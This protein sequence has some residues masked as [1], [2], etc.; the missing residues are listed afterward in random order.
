MK[1]FPRFLAITG[2]LS[3]LVPGAARAQAADPHATGL[4]PCT[5][6]ELAWQNKHMLRVKKVKLNALGLAR[7]NAA[8][9][10]KG[11][12]ALGAAPVRVGAEV[13]GTVGGAPSAAAEEGGSE[14]PAADLPAY[15]D[16]SSLKY[17]P[18]I[19]SQG[20]LPSCACFSG[21]YYVMTYM[22]AMAN[23]LDAKSGGDAVRLS[24]KFTYNFVNDGAAVGSWYYWAYDIGKKHGCATW[25]EFPYDSNYRAWPMSGA[26]YRSAINKRFDAYGYVSGTN[27]DSGIQQVKEMLVN[28][29]I[30]NI[31]TYVNSWQYRTIGNDPAT[32]EDDAFV[33]KSAC[34]WVNGTNGYHAMTVV[35]YNDH[36]WVDVNGNASVD[37]GEKGA[38]RI[39][40]SWGTGWGE[41]GYRWMAYDALKSPSGVS[42]GPSANRQLGWSPA[43]AHWITARTNY[44]PTMVAEF[45]VNHLKRNQLGM[46]LGL[47]A[48]NQTT[49]SSTWYP[50]EVAYYSGGPYAFNGGTTAVDGTFYYD[51]TDLVPP[52]TETK[53]WY[54]GMRDNATGDVATIKV[55]RLYEVTPTGDVPVGT[56][57]NVPQTADGG[58]QVYAWVDYQYNSGNVAPAA[59]ATVTPTSG[60]EGQTVFAFDGTGSSDPDGVIA[61]Y[62]WAF[63]DGA[64]ANGANATHT[65]ASAGTFTAMLTVTDNMGATGT[66]TVSV[67]VNPDPNKVVH[68][69]AIDMALT[70]LNKKFMRATATVFV[71][72]RNDAPI[73]GATVTG[74]WSGVESGTAE[75]VTDAAGAA[76]LISPKTGAKGGTFTLTVTDVSAGG[77]GYDPAANVENSDLISFGDAPPPP[78][79]P[80]PPPGTIFVADIAM[81]AGPVPGGLAATATVLVT[82]TDGNPVAGAKVEGAWTGAYSGSKS[83]VTGADGRAVVSTKKTKTGGTFT[84]TVTNVSTDADTYDPTLNAETSDSVTYY[85]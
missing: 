74:T 14:T 25:S 7:V 27:T 38:F 42:G 11:L 21:T 57:A 16:N 72:D 24:P 53:R 83:A 51:F 67:I 50:Y 52:A 55:F 69:A 78:P 65:Y 4:A 68:V 20:S 47:S 2:I 28:G 48:T 59:V 56:A 22:W 9:K 54:V 8:R 76:V 12:P 3:L 75:A 49:P 64:N 13:E 32:T 37:A 85:P 79:P 60:I 46:T 6:E 40:N 80:P 82:D 19:R 34:F 70:P 1:I 31:P 71:A 18:P 5:P 45:T 58:E 15:L 30:L 39:A 63:G 33:G 43:R 26:T 10:A 41:S 66:D 17:F 23:D 61:S 81:S 29:Y 44:Q 62:A 73:A 84:F 35:G 36:I 77:Y